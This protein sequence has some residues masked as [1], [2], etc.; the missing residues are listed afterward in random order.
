VSV[1]ALG[2]K[3][4]DIVRDCYRDFSVG[5]PNGRGGMWWWYKREGGCA[6]VALVVVGI[7]PAAV[8]EASGPV[9]SLPDFQA[10]LVVTQVAAHTVAPPRSWFPAILARN[11]HACSVDMALGAVT[12]FE[13]FTTDR[14][15]VSAALLLDRYSP[16]TWR[17]G[18]DACCGVGGERRKGGGERRKGGGERRKGGGERRKG[19]GGIERAAIGV[20][21]SGGRI[22]TG[23]G[24]VWKKV[25][26]T[27]VGISFER[28]HRGSDKAGHTFDCRRGRRSGSG[29]RRIH[30][31]R[32]VDL[33]SP[34]GLPRRER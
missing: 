15:D 22:A 8:G 30:L 1:V 14:T 3:G 12:A 26:A 34:R 18:Q 2:R 19:G 6:V 5:Q 17:F 24:G 29:T 33:G 20:G 7:H 11:L 31:Q 9:I 28:S 25:G 23:S 21:L 27:R 13:E 10:S 4:G 16:A 32:G